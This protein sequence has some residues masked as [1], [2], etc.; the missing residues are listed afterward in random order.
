MSDFKF[1]SPGTLLD[2]ALDLAYF[3]EDEDGD[4]AIPFHRV[5]GR[6]RLILVVGDNASGKSFFRR[7]VQLL[8]KKSDIECMAI[9]A[10]ARR[11]ISYN[12]WLTFVYGDEEHEA[13]GVNSTNTVLTGIKTCQGRDSKHVIFWDEPDLG[14]SDSWAAGVGQKL[15]QFAQ[16]PPKHT[17]A[18]LV[19]SHNR[20]L[21]RELLPAKPFYLHLGVKAEEAPPTLQEWVERPCAPRDPDRLPE[22]SRKRFKMIQHILNRSKP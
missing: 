6:G 18:A 9:S 20:A 16:E 4:V 17:V 22:Q 10:E 7:I 12:P 19:V 2:R 8:C 5:N 21:V 1:S 15:C 3:H 11:T 13:T 14:L